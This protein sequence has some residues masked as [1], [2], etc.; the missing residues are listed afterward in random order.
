MTTLPRA[1]DTLL[2]TGNGYSATRGQPREV[3]SVGG[4][5]RD[6]TQLTLC[7]TDTRVCDTVEAVPLA[8][9]PANRRCGAIPTDTNGDGQISEADADS[10]VLIDLPEGGGGAPRP[11][12]SAPSPARTGP[13]STTSSSTRAAAQGDEDLFRPSTP[14]ARPTTTRWPSRRASG[15]R[16]PRI[17]PT[18]IVGPTSASTPTAR[19]RSTSSSSPAAAD[20]ERGPGLRA[21]GRHALRRR[22]R[23]RPGL[24]SRRSSV[25]FRRLM[26]TG[27]RG[28]G[29]WEILTVSG[30]VSG[31][32]IIAR[33]RSIAAPPTG[34]PG[35]RLRGDRRRRGHVDPGGRPARRLGAHRHPRRSALFDNPRWLR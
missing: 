34:A 3:F 35:D 27:E 26:A 24:F 28:L 30:N 17:D 19:A 18:G 10:L 9:P 4:R 20:H 15:E 14:T 13:P 2:F 31:E 5:R 32:R 8:G 23:R 16:R 21:P 6:L 22:L 29:V 25:V 7:N 12:H 11:G 33:V 1:A